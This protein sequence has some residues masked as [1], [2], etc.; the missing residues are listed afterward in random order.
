M[1]FNTRF[2]IGDKA[3]V[4][5]W[6]NH[7]TENLRH[8][9]PEQIT[10]GRVMAQLTDSPGI[11]GEELFDNYKPQS[12][13][14]EE[15]MAVETGIGSGNVYTL[16]EHIFSTEEECL[17]VTRERIRVEEERRIAA[18]TAYELARARERN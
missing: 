10:I 18:N 17:V 8:F 11:E 15:Y 13:Y 5:H 16:G 4:P 14:K 9:K 1:Q 12:E 6:S 3:W 7:R 2:S